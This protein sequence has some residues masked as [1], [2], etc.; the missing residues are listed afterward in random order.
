MLD[1]TEE[2]LDWVTGLVDFVVEGAQS[3]PVGTWG[4]VGLCAA[5]RDRVDQ[6]LG[7]IGF[8]GRDRVGRDGLKEAFSLAHVGCLSGSQAPARQVAEGCDQGMSLRGQYAARSPNG[9]SFFF[10]FAPA[11]G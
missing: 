2:A 7:V 6:G 5:G 11:A 4:N 3:A 9:L 10:F 1:P 8:I